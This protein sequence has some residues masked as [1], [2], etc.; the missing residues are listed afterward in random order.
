VG[1]QEQPPSPIEVMVQTQGTSGKSGRRMNI[2]TLP[3][4]GTFFG[5]ILMR[6]NGGTSMNVRG[7]VC[8]QKTH[9]NK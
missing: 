2:Q 5:R 3:Q 1:M 7:G 8:A 6:G 4:T 9:T